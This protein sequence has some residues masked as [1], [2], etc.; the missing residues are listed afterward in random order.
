MT[1]RLKSAV[2]NTKMAKAIRHRTGA[3][4]SC[5]TVLGQSG[6]SEESDVEYKGTR[7][8]KRTPQLSTQSLQSHSQ[9]ELESLLNGRRVQTF[10]ATS[11]NSKS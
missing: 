9:V 1:F 11:P 2:S 7:R 6:S 8:H 3:G 5:F 10:H 4:F